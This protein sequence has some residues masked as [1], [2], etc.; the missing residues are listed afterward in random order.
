MPWDK[1]DPNEKVLVAESEEDLYELTILEDMPIG[2]PLFYTDKPFIY[3]VNLKY[4]ESRAQE[5]IQYI[6]NN[7]KRGYNLELW[8]IWLD[9]QQET[10]P[11][12]VDI[13]AL[14][15]QHIKEMYDFNDEKFTHHKGFLIK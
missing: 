8:N 2:D 11:K 4:T 10:V 3:Q 13:E 14:S 6:K 15:I 5:L 1:M 7:L 9:D 12:S